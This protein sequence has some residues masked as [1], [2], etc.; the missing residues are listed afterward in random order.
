MRFFTKAAI[1]ALFCLLLLPCFANAFDL[2]NFSAQ[3]DLNQNVVLSWKTLSEEHNKFIEIQHSKDGQQYQTISRITGEAKANLSKNYQFT[4]QRVQS[5]DHFYRLR[6]ITTTGS[7]IFSAVRKVIIK[8]ALTRKILI[9]ANPM[10]GDILNVQI[11]SIHDVIDFH[12]IDSN[13]QVV[14]TESVNKKRS[15]ILIDMKKVEAGKYSFK[16]FAKNKILQKGQI[17]LLN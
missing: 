13:G 7:E 9:A 8:K 6:Q 12:L 1:G 10:K 3:S 11:T 17:E 14:Y 15:H 4:H 2:T 16:L 5:G